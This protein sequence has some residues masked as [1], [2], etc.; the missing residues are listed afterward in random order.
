MALTLTIT[1][2]VVPRSMLHVSICTFASNRPHVLL[3]I[4]LAGS[5]QREERGRHHTD[6]CNETDLDFSPAAFSQLADLSVGRLSDMTWSRAWITTVHSTIILLDLIGLLYF[7]DCHVIIAP[8][9]L[10]AQT[11][12]CSSLSRWLLCIVLYSFCSY[13][14]QDRSYWNFIERYPVGCPGLSGMSNM[15]RPS[16]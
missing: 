9:A 15:S 16:S 12:T 3:M 4:R 11:R 5:D 2:S 13:N 14:S 7:S 6:R 8:S 1:R 10:S